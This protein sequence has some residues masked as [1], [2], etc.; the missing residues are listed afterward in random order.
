MNAKAGFH[1]ENF[2]QTME[3]LN[4][5]NEPGTQSRWVIWLKT[6]PIMLEPQRF[7]HTDEWE[8]NPTLQ[9][10]E[11]RV[12]FLWML[13]LSRHPKPALSQSSRGLQ[14]GFLLVEESEK[15]Q[16]EGA[17]VGS[18]NFNLG[19]EE[20]PQLQ[21]SPPLLGKYHKTHRYTVRGKGH[22]A[23]ERE[24][25]SLLTSCPGVAKRFFNA[26]TKS[27]TWSNFTETLFFKKKSQLLWC[28]FCPQTEG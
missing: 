8:I 17:W 5:C 1:P 19:L 4:F 18:P 22:A 27:F 23:L 28:P 26:A 2:C 14:S 6:P 11:T 20:F 9:K 24:R 12:S 16:T 15:L 13:M 21:K 7:Q 3:L 25:P 10:A